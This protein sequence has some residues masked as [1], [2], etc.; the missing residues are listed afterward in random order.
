LEIIR[1][2][3]NGKGKD[4]RVAFLPVESKINNYKYAF[5]RYMEGASLMK[6]CF[7]I[8]DMNK[9]NKRQLPNYAFNLGKQLRL[10]QYTGYQLTI[11]RHCYIKEIQ[12]E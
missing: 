4:G 2:Q 7:E 11:G 8:Y 3:S 1:Y 12:T 6:I 9:I 5:K 10:Y